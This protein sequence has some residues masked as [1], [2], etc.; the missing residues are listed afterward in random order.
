MSSLRKSALLITAAV[1]VLACCRDAVAGLYGFDQAN[2]L[3]IEEQIL[4]LD[5][6]PEYIVNYREQM[7]NNITMLA[8]YAKA[9]NPD[10][11]I[12]VHEGRKLLLKGLWE[13][14]L[15]GYNE[16]KR[17][18]TQAKDPS[19]LLR[20]KQKM[21]LSSSL[22]DSSTR[23]YLKNLDA[24]VLNNLFCQG[25]PQEEIL[26]KQGIPVISVDECSSEE[27]FDEAIQES[28]G[29]K[30]L[31]YGFVN[32]KRAFNNLRYQPV[33]NENA[34]NV[35]QIG[36]TANIAFL[37]DDSAY[38]SKDEFIRDIRNSNFDIIVIPPLFHRN[39][40]YTAEE[41]NSLKFKKNGTKRLIIAE[42]NVSEASDRDYYW[43]ND[44]EI[45]HPDWLSRLSFVEE[46]QVITRYWHEEWKKIISRFFR[47]IV[48]IGFD[49]AFLTGLNNHEY[50]ERQTP[51]E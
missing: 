51:L 19:F 9:R 20:L 22:M 33:I 46:N 43:Q 3:T 38:G 7:R 25:Q 30:T 48:A 13:Y 10:F 28:V 36:D 24:V 16:A 21:P 45:G 26:K 1:G 47:D 35:F 41:V 50:F 49:G 37:I 17:F 12:I 42:L 5:E 39:T 31:L 11:K 23:N 27:A 15:Q 8:E 34:R 40:P 6:P 44:W 18:G 14:H 32:K 4:N 2:P 29:E